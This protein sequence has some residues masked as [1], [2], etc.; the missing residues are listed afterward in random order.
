[1]GES[2]AE[3]ALRFTL[4]NGIPIQPERVEQLLNTHT[5]EERLPALL[6]S[7]KAPP[8]SRLEPSMISKV[9][10][11]KRTITTKSPKIPTNFSPSAGLDTDSSPE[12][13]IDF[14]EPHEVSFSAPS[15]TITVESTPEYPNGNVH[16]SHEI[17][18]NCTAM[19]T[20]AVGWAMIVYSHSKSATSIIH[21]KACLGNYECKVQ[22]CNFSE[23]PRIP[24]G[25]YS[26]TTLPKATTTTCPRH[27]GLLCHIN[28]MATMKT[29]QA[30]NGNTIEVHHSG[31]HNHS[32][33]HPIRPDVN[34]KLRF[35]DIVRIAPEVC[36]KSLQIGHSTREPMSSVHPSYNNLDR[37]A[38]SR[39]KI[40]DNSRGATFGQF[41][42]F[43]KTIARENIASSQMHG[44]DGHIIFITPFQKELLQNHERALQTDSIEGF[45]LD[46]YCPTANV[47]MTTMLC[48]VI[49]RNVPV[50]ISVLLGKSAKHYAAHFRCIFAAMQMSTNLDEWQDTFPGNTCDFSDAERIG[51]EL[52]VREYCCINPDDDVDIA[53]YYQCCTV[54]FK[55]TL[56]RV[57]RNG[58]VVPA[59]KK[60]E[61]QKLVLDLLIIKDSDLFMER[62]KRLRTEYP[63]LEPW[64]KWHI[65]RGQFIFPAMAPELGNAMISDN[66]N[67]QECIGGDFQRTHGYPKIS[68]LGALKHAH[69]Y[70]GKI[71]S[72]YE[73]ASSGMLLRYKTKVFK[74]QR[75]VNDGRPPD[76]TSKL[77]RKE[78]KCCILVSDVR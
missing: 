22:D 16:Y 14:P 41:H 29:I 52:A 72:D 2:V 46:K 62:I 77:V 55:R 35:R 44:P 5:N 19:D 9:L 67:A 1:M 60:K 20:R 26:K 38:Y 25:S 65:D 76:T 21:R 48:E 12:S 68:I 34:A 49:N 15:S 78:K 7:T 33:P 47:T 4:D 27:G 63:K 3:Y 8:S 36:P 13:P 43:V 11:I 30:V 31:V 45:V 58:N 66:T 32:R 57:S 40:L 37:L 59:M 69:F 6:P 70:T 28:C 71:E 18:L 50:C 17:P 64:F 56:S 74:K 73:R 51:F 61:F 54:H 39:R 24:S 42:A 53:P 10:K 75:Y 23:R